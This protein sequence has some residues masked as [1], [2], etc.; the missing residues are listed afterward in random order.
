M[1]DPHILQINLSHGGVPKL[2]VLEANVTELG[3]EGD[4]HS[5]RRNHG[6]PERAVCL[7]A[8]ERIEALRAEGHPISPGSTGENITTAG[9]DWSL[10]VPGARLRLGPDLL[11]EVTR[12]TTPCTTIQRSFVGNNFARILNDQHPGDSR[13]YARILTPGAIRPGDPIELM[14]G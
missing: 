13:V 2:P 8:N 1:P 4:T 7:F 3:I 5:D 12:Y 14:T 6:G 11:I 9:L 10:V